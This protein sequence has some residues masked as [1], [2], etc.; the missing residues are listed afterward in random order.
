MDTLFGSENTKITLNF[1]DVT[2]IVFLEFLEFLET[3]FSKNSRIILNF[4]RNFREGRK[5]A[6]AF[7][8]LGF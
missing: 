1:H 8:L 5:P 6:R 4:S 3:N 2:K 7:E